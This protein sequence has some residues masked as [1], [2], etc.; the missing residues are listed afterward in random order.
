MPLHYIIIKINKNQAHALSHVTL[1]SRQ[2]K[3][4]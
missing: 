1:D 3:I 4:C 2:G